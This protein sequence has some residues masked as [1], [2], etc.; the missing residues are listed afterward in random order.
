MQLVHIFSIKS[1]LC[2]AAVALTACA[3]LP[4][5]S[6]GKLSPQALEMVNRSIYRI[7]PANCNVSNGWTESRGAQP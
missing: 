2:V 4:P 1:L 5:S 3:Q 7:K 6:Q